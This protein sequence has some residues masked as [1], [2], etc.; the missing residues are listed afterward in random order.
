M[1]SASNWTESRGKKSS[2]R[3][4]GAQYGTNYVKYLGVTIRRD[5]SLSKHAKERVKKAEK[6]WRQIKLNTKHMKPEQV[7]TILT[8]IIRPTWSFG[9][10]MWDEQG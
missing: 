7:K 10:E 8:S 1:I 5:G 6:M 3:T 4:P 2:S 9:A